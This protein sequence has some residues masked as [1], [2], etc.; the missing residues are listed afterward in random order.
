MSAQVNAVGAEMRGLRTNV[1][2]QL[3]QI[4]S[5]LDLLQRSPRPDRA[6][7]QV[8]TDNAPGGTRNNVRNRLVTNLLQKH[9]NLQRSLSSA[10][11]ER[12]Q[13]LQALQSKE[14]SNRV[15][16]ARTEQERQQILQA[17]QAR[18]DR[19]RVR[20]AHME[21]LLQQQSVMQQSINDARQQS[22]RQRHA[23][24]DEVDLPQAP[25]TPEREIE[26]EIPVQVVINVVQD[27]VGRDINVREIFEDN[28][29][30]INQNAGIIANAI[31]T[32][33]VSAR[34]RVATWL[35]TTGFAAVELSGQISLGLLNLLW[36]RSRVIAAL[37][38][39][40]GFAYACRRLY[41]VVKPKVLAALAKLE[42]LYQRITTIDAL[43]QSIRNGLPRVGRTPLTSTTSIKDRLKESS[44]MWANAAIMAGSNVPAIK[45]DIADAQQ[46]LLTKA[47]Q[48]ATIFPSGR[49]P[50]VPATVQSAESSGPPAQQSSHV[51]QPLEMLTTPFKP[52]ASLMEVMKGAVP[53][54]YMPNDVIY[55]TPF[56]RVL[57]LDA[58]SLMQQSGPRRQIKYTRQFK[59]DAKA[60]F[61]L[62]F[63]EYS[64]SSR[65]DVQILEKQVRQEVTKMRNDI[66]SA[67]YGRYPQL[68][69]E[70]GSQN[71]LPAAENW[72]IEAAQERNAE[73]WGRWQHYLNVF[74]GRAPLWSS[75]SPE[76]QQRRRIAR[77]QASANAMQRRMVI[78][79]PT[80]RLPPQ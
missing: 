25:R 66:R 15:R 48:L 3:Q 63:P 18:E 27:D 71:E 45:G 2:S 46:E 17:L 76:E 61:K 11:Q 38:I 24:R 13:I 10:A 12:Q 35:Q 39:V 77:E 78:A 20:N 43:L 16:N 70:R 68:A 73:S 74:A 60:L 9:N 42:Y 19:D 8:Q 1:A 56:L 21:Q 26:P 6:S 57:A 50:P 52:S 69:Q 41:I 29:E 65:A 67:L 32:E 75:A 72:N 53:A 31:V 62:A 4:K 64:M 47:G 34:R 7:V 36:K 33:N 54:L 80:W 37:S 23:V 40:L 44:D 28:E 55:H 49:V 51:L 5:S 14:D 59:L 58:A 22:N 79:G 30:V